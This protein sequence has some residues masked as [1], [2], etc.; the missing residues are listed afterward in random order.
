[1]RARGDGACHSLAVV[2]QA[3]V[4]LVSHGFPVAS[5]R[6]PKPEKDTHVLQHWGQF[7][8]KNQWISCRP[9]NREDSPP[10]LHAD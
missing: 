5:G 7:A 8:G 6:P 1:M 10:V 2:M 9:E 4:H 3:F